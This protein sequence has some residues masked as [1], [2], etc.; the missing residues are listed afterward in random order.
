MQ[1]ARHIVPRVSSITS[2]NAWLHDN[3]KIV[4]LYNA[5]SVNKSKCPIIL[6]G[7]GKHVE[8]KSYNLNTGKYEYDYQKV[9]A[10]IEG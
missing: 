6:K 4:V 3:V 8:M 10:A 7:I 9:R 5:A 1:S 2:V